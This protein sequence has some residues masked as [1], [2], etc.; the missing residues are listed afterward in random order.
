MRPEDEFEFETKQDHLWW[1]AAGCAF[2]ALFFFTLGFLSV[3]V[4]LPR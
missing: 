2:S 3:I 4:N 1:K